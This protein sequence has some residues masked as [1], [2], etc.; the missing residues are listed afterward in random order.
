M[1][2]LGTKT[3]DGQLSFDKYVKNNPKWSSGMKFTVE[4]DTNQ[5]PIVDI[6]QN[7]P[8]ETGMVV[9]SGQP[10]HIM[11]KSFKILGRSKYVKIK[12]AG[13]SGIQGYL[14]ISYIRK[15]TNIDVMKSETLAISELDQAIKDIQIPVTIIVNKSSG[16]GAFVA[17][18]IIEVKKVP[19]IPK[20]D[21]A[22]YDRY[23]TPQMW[24]S[25]KKEGDASA[26]QQYS[27]VSEKSGNAIYQHP[28]SK[29]FMRN[30]IKYLEGEGVNENELQK[31]LDF[32]F[33]HDIS[34][35]DNKRKANAILN[36]YG[37]QRL[38]RQIFK[39]D[40][41]TYS[42][43]LQY[44]HDYVDLGKL[45]PL[46]SKL[47]KPLYSK[48]K[49]AKL[50][51]MAMFGNDAVTVT[52]PATNFG[53]NNVQ[54]IGQGKPILTPLTDDGIFDLSFSSHNITNEDIPDCKGGSLFDCTYEPVFAA[55]FRTGRGFTVDNEAYY[56]ARL[57]IYPLAITKRRKEMIEI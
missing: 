40:I 46:T 12:L 10:L 17:Q 22:L 33:S 47:S 44:P 48:I 5:A 38:A 15:P 45:K 9:V 41:P 51:R 13:G 27:G 26:F 16:T 55:T 49:S 23:G 53:I 34:E 43:F 8:V 54:L 19:G 52:G 14:N 25:H 21:L 11:S 18:E 24:I 32:L 31:S 37:H 30:V 2:H 3:S 1:A 35:I 50:K 57:G 42:K 56:G 29:Q 28:E 6:K 20:A 39:F 7:K 36:K 4:N